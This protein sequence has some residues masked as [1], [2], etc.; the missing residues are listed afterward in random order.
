MFSAN[1]VQR[2]HFCARERAP[3]RG[4]LIDSTNLMRIVVSRQ[5]LLPAFS[6]TG[7]YQ[8][9]AIQFTQTTA[10]L[11]RTVSV[12]LTCGRIGF[13]LWSVVIN[14]VGIIRQERA[15]D[16]RSSRMTC[17]WLKPLSD[18]VPFYVLRAEDANVIKA[19]LFRQVCSK[20]SRVHHRRKPRW[21]E[22]S[23]TWRN[24]AGAS[25]DSAYR[26]SNP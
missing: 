7:N 26:G 25:S 4:K 18:T 19:L 24:R 21:I 1:N 15:A 9:C 11:Q 16:A 12:G 17:R 3:A 20:F 6:F 8:A 10:S 23:R 13:I 5:G 22:L 2:F 14:T